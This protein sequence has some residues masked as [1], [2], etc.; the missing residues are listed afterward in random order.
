MVEVQRAVADGLIIRGHDSAVYCR[1][2][3]VSS[4][5]LEIAAVPKPSLESEVSFCRIR[6]SC[7]V[8]VN[9]NLVIMLVT[10]SYCSSLL[11]RQNSHAPSLVEGES[12]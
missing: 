8:R 1:R 10:R 11:P 5:A 6:G 3:Y 9:R 7:E 2:R 12:R 4:P